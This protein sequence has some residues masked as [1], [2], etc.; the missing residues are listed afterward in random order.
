M[1]SAG[2]VIAK[3]LIGSAGNEK[4]LY[5]GSKATVK[6]CLPAVISR[7]TEKINGASPKMC[8]VLE[9]RNSSI[10]L[11]KDKENDR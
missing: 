2:A 3:C 6:R 10:S 7:P 4:W 9:N 1:R 5:G 8:S 11:E